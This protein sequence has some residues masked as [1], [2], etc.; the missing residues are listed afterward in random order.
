V[1]DEADELIELFGD[2]GSEGAVS[3]SFALISVIPVAE[4]N[5][6]F[7]LV[8]TLCSTFIRSRSAVTIPL[9]FVALEDDSF[10]RVDLVD[11]PLFFL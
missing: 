8:V 7:V 10:D 9:G 6:I 2:A 3:A 5:A 11:G 1:D 4:K